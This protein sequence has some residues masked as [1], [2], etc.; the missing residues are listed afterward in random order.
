MNR[1]ESGLVPYSNKV[2]VYSFGMILLEVLELRRPW[3]DE[4]IGFQFKF[5]QKIESGHRPQTYK[6]FSNVPDGYTAL[7]EACWH[8]D[9]EKR[10]SFRVVTKQIDALYSKEPSAALVQKKKKKKKAS[11]PSVAIE[12]GNMDVKDTGEVRTPMSL[13]AV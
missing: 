1:R 11:R 10:P 2:D 8:M 6:R 3:A 4:K 12:M 13:Y 9:P 5:C 7:M